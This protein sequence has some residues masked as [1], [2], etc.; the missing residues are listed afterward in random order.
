VVTIP[1]TLGTNGGPNIDNPTRRFCRV[2]EPLLTQVR[3]LATYTIPRVDLLVSGTWS[4]NP[5][6]QLAANWDVPAALV[7]P[8]LGRPLSGG[9]ATTRVNLVAPATLYGDRINNLDFRVAKIVRVGRTR[10]QI[11][12]DFYNVL[13]NDVVTG[14]NSTYVP[15]GSWL[16]P[17]AILPARYLKISGQFDF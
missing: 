9:A 14:Y 2:V 16:A 4:S 15:S 17:T 6:P 7:A 13:N 5:G 3:G 10:T 1:G 8:S 11:G 12:L